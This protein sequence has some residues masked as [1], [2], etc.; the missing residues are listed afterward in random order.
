MS[1]S[2][3]NISK[4]TSEEGTIHTHVFSAKSAVSAFSLILEKLL[5]RSECFWLLFSTLFLGGSEIYMGK[6]VGLHLWLN[7]QKLH[8]K[9]GHEQ[10]EKHLSNT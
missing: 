4:A 6:F 9:Q 8:W 10:R 3:R 1:K 5:G 2:L 7:C